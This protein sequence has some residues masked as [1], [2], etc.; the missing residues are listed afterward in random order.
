[1]PE[2][3]AERGYRAKEW[4][5]VWT[6]RAPAAPP[7]PSKPELTVRRM[8]S[9]QEELYCRVMLAGALERED[10]PRAAIDLLLP[11]AVADCYELYLAWL[12]DEAIGAATLGVADDIAFLNGCAVRPAFRRRGAHD[13]L[14]RARLDRACELGLSVSY[15]SALPGTASCRHLARRGFTVSYPKIVMAADVRR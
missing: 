5:L 8:H 14:I 7:E 6:R 11:M 1:V 12:G 4:Q 10:V 9:G 15:A 13:A 2:L 3:L